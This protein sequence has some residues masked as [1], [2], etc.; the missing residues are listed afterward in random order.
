MQKCQICIYLSRSQQ[1][2]TPDA[3][4]LRRK[5]IFCFAS[6][7]R[8]HQQTSDAFTPAQTISS[9][10]KNRGSIFLPP[11]ACGFTL[12]LGDSRWRSP[13]FSYEN[14]GLSLL[15]T[16]LK[17]RFKHL[18]HTFSEGHYFLHPTLI[19]FCFTLCH[20]YVFSA[21][22]PWDY[23]PSLPFRATV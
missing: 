11:L 7:F 1:D 10:C 18:G 22:A 2:A 19:C 8:G 20:P 12:P 5:A 13:V 4:L 15:N 14:L 17:L 6:P 21:F 9:P 3:V 16:H 23:P